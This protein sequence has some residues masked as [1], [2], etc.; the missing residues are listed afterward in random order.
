M[1]RL[2]RS[3]AGFATGGIVIATLGW[4][5]LAPFDGRDLRSH[6]RPA[7]SY[8][9]ALRQVEGLAAEDD[10]TI[11]AQCRL[12]L[13]HHGGRCGRVVVLFHGL[14]N[15]PQQF[16]EFARRVHERGANVM[17]VRLPHHGLADRMTSDLG[18]LRAAELAAFGDRVVDMARGLGDSVTVAGLSV[19]GTLALWIGQERA[20]V[21]RVVAIA[22]VLGVHAVAV[23]LTGPAAR[24]AMVL[25]DRMMWWD[26]QKKAELPGPPYC[27]PRFSSRAL[28]ESLRLGMAVMERARRAAPAAASVV[29][30]TVESDPAVRNPPIAALAA[31]WRRH[32]PDAIGT[33]EFAARLGLG[34]DMIDPLQ[35]YA[36]LEV[37]YPPLLE[38]M[39]R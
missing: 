12:R 11:H 9:D 16:D 32:A 31:A 19:G 29:L 21:D 6:P 14:T 22:P 17:V 24:L 20:D 23:P 34:H 25:P 7:T 18:R 27:Y 26:D 28:G 38:R 1:P 15:C 36:N 8:A 10:S 30:V 33:F 35:P 2:T 13:F 39:W 37:S 3:T 4:L 5:G